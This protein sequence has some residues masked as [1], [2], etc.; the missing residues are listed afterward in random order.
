MSKITSQKFTVEGFNDQAGWIGKLF[1]PLNSFITQVVGAFQNQITVEDNLYAEIKSVSFVNE[2]TN[3][4]IKFK[5]KF[6][7]YPKM[8]LVG[9]CIDSNGGYSSEHPLIQ[10]TF[11]DGNL[12]ISSISGLTLS[13]KYIINLLIIYG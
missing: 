4:P 2:T 8:V 3:Y 11:G 6:N 12:S 9:S 10:W 5:T 1:S 7:K 13:S